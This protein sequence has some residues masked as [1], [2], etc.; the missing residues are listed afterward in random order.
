MTS[1]TE[2]DRQAARFVEGASDPLTRR[3]ID[4]LLEAILA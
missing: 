2:R 3:V 4:E 1:Q